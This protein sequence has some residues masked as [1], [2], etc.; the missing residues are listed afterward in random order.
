MLA[1]RKSDGK[2][3][4]VRLY[5]SVAKGFAPLDCYECVEDGMYYSA[6]DLDFDVEEKTEDSDLRISVAKLR[7]V[8]SCMKGNLLNDTVIDKIIEKVKS[9]I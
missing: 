8:L 6:S 7:R 3:I 4:E 2:V 1:K 5:A 9:E